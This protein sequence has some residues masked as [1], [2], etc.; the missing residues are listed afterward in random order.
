VPKTTVARPHGKKLIDHRGPGTGRPQYAASRWIAEQVPQCGDASPAR[1]LTAAALLA[2]HPN[3]SDQEIVRR[4][5]K[6]SA[7]ARQYLDIQGAIKARP[8]RG[9]D[10]E[11]QGDAPSVPSVGRRRRRRESRSLS[12]IGPGRGTRRRRLRPERHADHQAR[13]D[14]TVHI[15]RPRWVRGVGTRGERL[16]RTQELEAEGRT[17]ASI[18]PQTIPSTGSCSTAGSLV[19]E[20]DV[21][22]LSRDGGRPSAPGA[23][24]RRRENSGK[25]AR[26]KASKRRGMIRHTCRSIR[27]RS[28]GE[29]RDRRQLVPIT[30]TFPRTR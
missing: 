5:G 4:G 1:P 14:F 29:R 27:G 7:G 28:H 13:R 22:R 2:R 11:T 23:D 6:P 18:P 12:A 20:M 15:R 8:R 19:G 17:F 26:Q 30:K 21:R 25:C 10:R 9:C 3:P 16:V 24:R